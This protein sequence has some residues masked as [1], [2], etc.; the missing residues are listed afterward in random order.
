MTDV[1]I[2]VFNHDKLVSARLSKGWNAA[3]LAK[4][5]NVSRGSVSRWESGQQ[6]PRLGQLA[7]LC[8]LLGVSKADLTEPT[9]TLKKMDNYLATARQA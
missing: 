8:K 5:M 3:F 9:P 7:R 6:R 4:K 1:N 2:L